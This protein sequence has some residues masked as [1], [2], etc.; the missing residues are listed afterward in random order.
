LTCRTLAID[1]GAF[2]VGRS[3]MSGRT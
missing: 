3:I 2:F 1:E